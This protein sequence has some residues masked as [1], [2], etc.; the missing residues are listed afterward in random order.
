MKTS[1]LLIAALAVATTQAQNTNDVKGVKDAKE[2]TGLSA[3]AG[4]DARFR[5][6]FKDNAP[7]FQNNKTAATATD[8]QDTK[9]QDYY[10]LRTR[11]W[12]KASYED[13][14][15]FGRVG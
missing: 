8:P 7:K 9:Y 5:Y 11:V 4:A 15:L 6:D 10:R 2:K 3:K 1:M 14:T 12:G 13:Y